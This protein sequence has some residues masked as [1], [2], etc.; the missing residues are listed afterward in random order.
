MLLENVDLLIVSDFANPIYK[1]RYSGPYVLASYLRRLGL[2][3]QIV[4]YISE[5]SDEQLR[6]IVDVCVGKN[7]KAVGISDTFSYFQ[8]HMNANRVNEFTIAG[9][10]FLREERI[11]AFVARI[12]GINPDTQIIMGGA[13]STRFD[14][15]VPYVDVLFRGFSEASLAK[16]LMSRHLGLNSSSFV[17]ELPIDDW[18]D[19]VTHM[20]PEDNPLVNETVPL[21]ISRGCIFNCKYCSYPRKGAKD[22]DYIKTEE[23]LYQT[24]FTNYSEFGIRRYMLTDDTH[25]DSM[26]KLERLH[27]VTQRLPFKIEYSSYIRVD[28]L[29]RYPEMIDL[30]KEIGLKGAMMGIETLNWETGKIIGKGLQP[31]KTIETL[32][33]LREKWGDTIGTQGMFILGL[34]R[35]SYKDA[36]AMCERISAEDFPLHEALF[37]PLYFL[38][39]ARVKSAFDMDYESFGYKVEGK[40]WVNDQG[41]TSEQATKLARYYT[42]KNRKSGREKF[43]GNLPLQLANSGYVVDDLIGKP[44]GSFFESEEAKGRTT[45]YVRRYKRKLFDVEE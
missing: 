19:T 17:E 10:P 18:I 23:S 40:T 43:G 32:Q 13:K 38:T 1:S 39:Q 42:N 11:K 8:T 29:H 9:W 3:V 41:M 44:L 34:P 22:F 28:L 24:L 12:K 2:R 25:N 36:I 30:L 27:R 20:S 7:T 33:L 31:K 26:F 21:E 14:Q 16:Y 5:F 4:D 15:P 6:D 37:F 45:E 35:Q